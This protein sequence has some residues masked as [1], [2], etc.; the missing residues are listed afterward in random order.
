MHYIYHAPGIK[1]GCTSNYPQ[2]CIEQGFTVYELLETHEDGW[3]AGDRERE[4]QKQ[5]NYPIDDVHYMIS[6]Q[7]RRKWTMEDTRKGIASL[8][9]SGKAKKAQSLGGINATKKYETCPHCNKPYKVPAVYR[10]HFDN[11]KHIQHFQ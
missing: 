11:C 6:R 1:I 5:Y 4:L 2:R 7:N 3:F 8:Q 10:W 9:R